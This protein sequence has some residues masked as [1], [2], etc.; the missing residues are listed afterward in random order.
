MITKAIQIGTSDV[1]LEAGKK[2]TIA[3]H[4]G[5][6]SVKFD[7]SVTTWTAGSDANVDLPQNN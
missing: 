4:I 7:A 3:M 2:Y 6:T 5:L 1:S